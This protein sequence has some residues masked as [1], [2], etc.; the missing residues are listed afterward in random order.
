MGNIIRGNKIGS[1]VDSLLGWGIQV[2]KCQNTIVE[3][4]IVQNLKVT[5][6]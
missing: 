4:N 3:N 2:E 6:N 5:S 1:E